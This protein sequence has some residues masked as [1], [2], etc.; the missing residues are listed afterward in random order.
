M[1]RTFFH[2]TWSKV[3]AAWMAMQVGRY[4]HIYLNQ[5]LSTAGLKGLKM[6]DVIGKARDGM[7]K[8]VEVL[9]R[10]ETCKQMENKLNYIEK[11]NEGSQIKKSISS[12]PAVLTNTLMQWFSVVADYVRDRNHKLY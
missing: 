11:I 9:S 6:P 10:S 5:K 3:R 1:T 8:L 2:A 7:Y 12:W 4:E